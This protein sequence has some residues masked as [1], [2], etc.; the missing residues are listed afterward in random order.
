MVTFHSSFITS[1]GHENI[2]RL[3]MNHPDATV[4]EMFLNFACSLELADALPVHAKFIRRIRKRYVNDMMQADKLLADDIGEKWRALGQRYLGM[5]IKQIGEMKYRR[6]YEELPSVKGFRESLDY[7]RFIKYASRRCASSKCG[8]AGGWLKKCSLCKTTFYCNGSCQRNHWDEHKRIC[9]ESRECSSCGTIGRMEK[10]S[11][12]KN[13]YYCNE[14]CQTDH[15]E[16]HKLVCKASFYT[17]FVKNPS[18]RCASCGAV[19]CL[20][21][22]TSCTKTHYCN[23]DCQKAHW[24]EHKK[25]CKYLV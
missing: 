20:K 4:K 11:R 21:K 3:F 17:R 5:L 1:H 10:C 6:A 25:T 8:F 18:R 2:Q 19:G 13:A 12:C 7:A 23:E 15:W 24:V 22:C 9:R 14:D 16:Y